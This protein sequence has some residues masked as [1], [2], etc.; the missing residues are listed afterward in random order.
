ML[1]FA[2]LKVF[3][4]TFPNGVPNTTLA[5]AVLAMNRTSLFVTTFAGLFGSGATVGFPIA[6]GG[7]AFVPISPLLTP[8]KLIRVVGVIARF[9]QRAPSAVS[10]AQTSPAKIPTLSTGAELLPAKGRK[11]PSAPT[12]APLK[13]K[14]YGVGLP[15][16]SVGEH[17]PPPLL[18][19]SAPCEAV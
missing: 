14:S 3:R 12:K 10:A 8:F 17:A 6:S 9:P 19:F 2:S 5:V 13:A 11:A 15:L 16:R 1:V 4:A 7:P 18:Q